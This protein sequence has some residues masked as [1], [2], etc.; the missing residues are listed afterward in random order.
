MTNLAFLYSEN[1]LKVKDF[2]AMLENILPDVNIVKLDFLNLVDNKG[3]TILHNAALKKDLHIIQ[4][5]FKIIKKVDKL[6]RSNFIDAQNS[7]KS[8]AFHLAV[9]SCQNNPEGSSDF[10][11]CDAIAKLFDAEGANK[12]I[13]NKGGYVIES[14]PQPSIKESEYKNNIISL[15]GGSISSSSKY[16]SSPNPN[17]IK[18]NL[19]NITTDV[20]IDHA[21]E[22]KNDKHKL[23]NIAT[24]VSVDNMVKPKKFTSLD[25]ITSEV[26]IDNVSDSYSGSSSSGSSG[27]SSESSSISESSESSKKSGGSS[28]I[29]ASSITASSITASS[30]TDS[31][32][33]SASSSTEFKGGFTG[34]AQEVN[35]EQSGLSDTS[36]FVKTLLTQ[37]NSMKGGS[38]SSRGER[39]LPSLSDYEASEMYGGRDLGLSR[40]QMKESSN[41]H[42]NVVQMFVDSGKTE[43]EARIMKMA[44]YKYTKDKH[45]E[46][47]NL[48]RARK[49]QEFAADSSLLKKLDLDSTRKIYDEV[50]KSKSAM[51]TETSESQ[52]GPISLVGTTEENTEESIEKEKKKKT[53]KKSKED[54][55]EKKPSK[56]ATKK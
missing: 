29:T 31:S 25:N 47:N 24:E 51:T 49:M 34:G 55:K 52:N 41:I 33:M 46:L 15:Y 4:S 9:E 43:E 53:T 28:S 35:S 50:K 18:N 7:N 20:S 45:P 37:F 12:N 36:A 23:A 10:A 39:K 42:D 30:N 6:V 54:K 26:S 40:E 56:K 44:L 16:S 27:G 8:T 17:L 48:D 3:N 5:I 32:S 11:V 14:S 13:K 22:K 21:W 38:K 2:L 19:E 1:P